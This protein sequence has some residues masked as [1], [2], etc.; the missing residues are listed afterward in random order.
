MKRP[1]Y[2]VLCAVEVLAIVAIALAMVLPI[3]DYA[4]KEY[5]EWQAHPS[6]QTYQL[7]MEK[8]RQEHAARLLL[9]APA[10]VA[11]V[12]VAGALN[13]HRAKRR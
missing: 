2:A 4:L 7:F 8:Q 12:V 9:A 10:V 5:L 6:P 11:A 13:K 1:L 3:Q